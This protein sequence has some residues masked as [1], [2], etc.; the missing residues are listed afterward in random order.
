[1]V[2]YQSVA[3]FNSIV[4]QDCLFR[5]MQLTWKDD[6]AQ[7]DL[8]CMCFIHLRIVIFWSLS[9]LVYNYLSL[10]RKAIKSFIFSCQLICWHNS[11]CGSEDDD[12][13]KPVFDP[14][15]YSFN[16]W[17]KSMSPCAALSSPCAKIQLSRD[18]NEYYAR[19]YCERLLI[20]S[21]ICLKCWEV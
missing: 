6:K 20:I 9:R 19:I 11:I 16:K 1:M 14:N 8:S 5:T 15:L 17:N 12:L 21:C 3:S 18:H 10:I 13:L 7:I 2:I 4:F